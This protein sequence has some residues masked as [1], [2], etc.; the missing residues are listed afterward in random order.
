M[1]DKNTVE[2]I[3]IL[4]LECGLYCSLFHAVEP[5]RGTKMVNPRW[6]KTV[7]HYVVKR[8]FRCN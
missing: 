7:V 4:E 2:T 5:L 6:Q 8:G 1:R 3:E